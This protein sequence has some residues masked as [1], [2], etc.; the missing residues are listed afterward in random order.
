MKAFSFL[1]ILESLSKKLSILATKM[2]SDNLRVNH[3]TI[4]R[5]LR[6]SRPFSRTSLSASRRASF[7]FSRRASFALSRR[8]SHFAATLTIL[9]TIGVGNVFA[10]ETVTWIPTENDL[11]TLKKDKSNSIHYITVGT[12]EK[13]FRIYAVRNEASSSTDVKLIF[14]NDKYKMDDN[15]MEK[16]GLAVFVPA[17]S[18]DVLDIRF[19]MYT[20]KT[21]KTYYASGET[22][23]N[24]GT[25]TASALATSATAY[26]FFNTYS[27]STYYCAGGRNGGGGD[28]YFTK[29]EVVFSSSGGGETPDPDPDQPGT[30]GDGNCPESGEIY[31][32]EV[33]SATYSVPKDTETNMESA[34][35]TVVN[36]DAYIGNKHSNDAGK[37]QITTKGNGTVY[38]NGQDGYIKLVLDC[39][40]QTGDVLT[41]TN[42]DGSNPIC[43]T[44]DKTRATTHVTTNNTFN[45]PAVFDE[46]ST[47]Y[48]WRA[49]S[50][51]TYLHD[52][53]ITR[54]AS[55]DPTC[56]AV[57]A[58]TDL[59]CSARTNSSLTFGWTAA[60]NAS[61]YVV[62]LYSDA[63][64]TTQVSS[65]TI[66]GT[67]CTFTGL[68]GNTTYYCKVQSKGDGTTYCTNGGTTNATSGTTLTTPTITFN[69]GSYTISGPELN[70]STL[71][72]SNSN[73]TVTYTVTN[74]NGTGASINGTSFTATST[75]TA[76]VKATQAANG[77]Y[78]SGEATA[79]ITVNAAPVTPEP[80]AV[81]QVGTFT[82]M[83]MSGSVNLYWTMPTRPVT[84]RVDIAS[85]TL[86]T[87]EGQ[88]NSSTITKENTNEIKV[89]YSTNDTWQTAGVKIPLA[90]PQTNVESI[91]FEYKSASN[92]SVDFIPFLY[93]G[94]TRWV[95]SGF[96]KLTPTEW[97]SHTSVITKQ[98]WGENLYSTD[99]TIL[100]V[101]FY[102]N[103]ATATSGTFYIRNVVLNQG[104]QVAASGLI[105]VRKEGSNP[106]TPTDGT[107][108]YDGNGIAATCTD[109][110]LINGTTY[111]YA[112]YAH[113]GQGNYSEPLYWQYTY[114][115][116]VNTYAPDDTDFPNPE[117]GFYEQVQWNANKGYD[118]VIGDSYFD[119][120][121][122][123]NRSLILRIY[124]MD[125]NELRTNQQL[126]KDFIAMFNA[127]MEKF[128][129]NG[130]KCILR[131][132]YDEN[133]GD[134]AQDASPEIWAAHLADLAEHLEANADV[135]YVVQA[136][137]LGVWGE[138]YYSSEGTGNDEIK[139][140]IKNNLIDQ[141]LAAVPANRCVQLRT[142]KFKRDYLTSKS[143]STDALT[144]ATAYQNTPKA[145][146]GHHNDAFLNGEEN[147]GT[148]E[149]R[150]TDMAYIAQEC[151]YVPIGGETNLEESQVNDLYDK[152]CKG[153]VAEA[154]MAQLHYSY[155]NYSYST[156]VTNKWRDEGSY[157]RMSKQLGYRFELESATLPNKATAGTQMNVQL[158]IKNVGYA[159]LYNER[160]A[161]IVLKNNTNT[162]SIQLKSDPRTWAP[163]KVTTTI[164][165]NIELPNNMVEGTYDMYLHLP[166]ASDNIANNPKYAVRFANQGIWESETGYNKLNKQVVV[167]A[168]ELTTYTITFKNGETVLQTST[169]EYG[170]TPE[171][172]GETPTKA[173]DAQYTYTFSGWNPAITAVTGNATYNAT[174][175]QTAKTY[176][177][178]LNTN[179]GT[180]NAGNVT[181]YTYGEGATLPTNVTKTG[182]TFGGW[183]ESADFQGDAVTTILTTATGNKTY[184]AKWTEIKYTVTFN[185]NGGTCTTTSATQSSYNASITLPTPTRD[186][187]MFTGWYTA[188][189]GGSKIGDAGDSYTPTADITLYAQWEHVLVFNLPNDFNT[190]IHEWAVSSSNSANKLQYYAYILVEVPEATSEGSVCWKGEGTDANRT[191]L[192]MYTD[193]TLDNSKSFTYSTSYVSQT[194]GS[195]NIITI[196]EKYYLKFSTTTDWKAANVKIDLTTPCTTPTIN[197][198]PQGATYT[199]N[200]AAAALSVTATAND[201][202]LSYQWQSSTDNSEF[203]NISGATGNEY[204]PSTT[205]VGTTYYRC[206]VTNTTGGCSVTSASATI[207]VNAA[208]EP[209]PGTGDFCGKTYDFPTNSLDGWDIVKT[210][211][212][213]DVAI[214]TAKYQ[215][216][217]LTNG[218]MLGVGITGNS[219]SV[220]I[221]TK[222]SFT[223]ITK[224]SMKLSSINTENPTF[225]VNVVNGSTVTKIFTTTPKTANITKA[226]SNKDWGEHSEAVNKLSGKIQIVF[227]S[228]SNSERYAAIDDLVITT[229]CSSTPDPT[230]YTVTYNLGGGTGT[231]PTQAAT[232]A[233]GTFTLASADGITKDGHTFAGWND[234]TTTYAAGATYTMPASN[235][236]LTAQWTPEKYNIRYYE[237]VGEVNDINGLKEISIDD[238]PTSYTILD[239]VTLPALPA[240][241]GYKATGW[242]TTWC[243]FDDGGTGKGWAGCETTLGH[244]AGYYGHA[245]YI[246]KYTAEPGTLY[247]VTV[248]SA[249]N[250]TVAADKTTNVAQG[251]TVT[252]TVT[253]ASGYELGI[254]TV[255]DASDNNVTVT[256]NTFIMPASNV[257]VSATFTAIETPDPGSY[258]LTYDENKPAVWVDVFAFKNIPEAQTLTNGTGNVYN[259]NTPVITD[260]ADSDYPI[261]TFTGW[262]TA[263]DGTGTSYD[264][265]DEIT[266]TENTILYA[267]WTP[268]TFDVKYFDTNRTTPLEG[269][270]NTTYTFGVGIPTLPT[271]TKPGQTF[272]GWIAFWD[273][274]EREVT[275]IEQT[276]W[277]VLQLAAQWEVNCTM[278]TTTFANTKYTI[279]S[280]ALDLRTLISSK[281]SENSE[282]EITYA[283]T[284]GVAATIDGYSFT[285]DRI[286]VVT[287][288]ATQAANGGYCEKIMTA[289]I[290]V[291]M[292][293]QGGCAQMFTFD[294]NNNIS[295]P[296]GQKGSSY[297]DLS[298][299]ATINGLSTTGKVGIKDM[300]NN[301]KTSTTLIDE[302]EI[303]FPN[304][305]TYLK[306]E[307]LSTPLAAGDVITIGTGQSATT[308]YII[309]I[310]GTQCTSNCITTAGQLY[311]IP[312]G[313]S[314]IGVTTFYIWSANAE[315]YLKTI[316]ICRP[317]YKITYKANNG[318]QEDDVVLNDAVLVAGCP[319]TFTVPAGKQFAGWKDGTGTSYSVGTIIPVNNL[320]LF[321]QWECIEPVFTV[322]C[323]KTAY[324]KDDDAK[325]ITV[326][327]TA[328][329]SGGVTYQWYASDK[330]DRTTGAAITGAT[331]ASYTP[332]NL[333]TAGTTYYWCEISNSCTT[334]KTPTIAI[335]VSENKSNPTVTWTYFDATPTQS[336]TIH[337]GGGSYM[338]TAKVEEDWNGTLTADML[339][340]PDGIYV[341]GAM[342][343][344]N[345]ISAYFDVTTS[346]NRVANPTEIPFYLTLP[347]T[348]EYKPLVSIGNVPYEACATG[349]GTEYV[350]PV[351]NG[352]AKKDG[353]YYYWG[354]ENGWVS[355]SPNNS[356][357]GK[358][359]ATTFA[360]G[361]KFNYVHGSNS[362]TTFVRTFKAG[363]DKVRIY[364]NFRA[365]GMTVTDVYKHSDY[366]SINNQ[367][368]LNISS[369][370]TII[371]N[372]DVNATNLGESEYGFVDVI[373]NSPL[374]QNE[375]IA[376]KFNTD[377]V[378]V[379]GAAIIEQSAGT[380]E[381]ALSF[382]T[383]G[384]IEKKQSD[385]NFTY[386][387]TPS[388]NTLGTITYSS[389]NTNVATVNPNTG[390]VEIVATGV[391]G[392]TTTITATLA[393]SGCY[394]G[395][396]ATYTISVA[397]M[398]CDISAGTLALTNGAE[399]KCSGESVTLA[400]TGY[401]ADG[402]TIQWYKGDAIIEGATTAT[403]TTAAP[404]TYSVLV[405]EN[406]NNA[407]AKRSNTITITNISAE[408]SVTNI[409]NTWYIKSGRLTPPIALWKLEEG[410]TFLSVTASDGWGTGTGF[411]DGDDAK[412]FFEKDGI[413]YLTGTPPQANETDED[414]TYT[415]TLK[416]KDVCGGEHTIPSTITIVHQKNTDKH[417]LAFVV[418][419]TEKGGF[420]E[421]I[422]TAQT[423]NVP[424][425][426]EI[427]QEFDVLATNIYATDNEQLL[428][429][430]YSRFDI[431][432]I[433]DYPN[434]KKIGVNGK[435]Y[436]DAMGALIDIRPIFSMEAWVSNL[437][438]WN[439][440][441][442]KGEPVS[443]TTRQYS[444][445]L[446]CKD[447]EIFAGTTLITEGSGDEEMYRVTM[448]DAT[449]EDY[450]NLDKVE[451][452]PHQ[453]KE[454][455]KYGSNPALQGFRYVSSLSSMLPIGT[456]E[457]GAGKI[458]QVGLERQ[459]EEEARMMV[460]GVNA[461]AMERLTDD[462]ETVIINTLKYLMKKSAE[463]ISDCSIF[464]DNKAG[465]NQWNNPANW[466]PSYNSVPLSYQGA[467][468]L[469]PCIVSDVVAKAAKVKIAT[470]GTYDKGTK[471][472]NGSLTI[473]PNGALVVG[474]VISEVTAPNYYE[475]RPTTEEKLI[476]QAEDESDSQ[477]RL[478]ALIHD[479]K[480]GET[481]ATIQMW[482]PSHWEIDQETG[483]KKKYWSYVAVPIQEAP[484]PEFFYHGF[485]YLYDE[486]QGWIKK[487]DGTV[488]YPFQG[489]GAS[490]QTGNKETFYGKL[491]TTADQDIILTKTAG[492]GEGQNLIGN[493]WTA[494]IQI[495][496]FEEED[497]N[498]ATATVYVYNT[499][500]DDVYKNPTYVVGSAENDGAAT[501]GQWIGIP[502]GVAGLAE[503]T[504]LK[505]IPAMNAFQV[506]TAQETELHLN[507]NRLVRGEGKGGVN[508]ESNLNQ[509]MR[510]PHK[511]IEALMR[512]R[513][514]GE[515]THTDMWLLQDERFDY[516]FDNGWEAEF[517]E[518]DD[519]SA[520]LYAV[521]EIG[522]MAFLA[523]PE[524][525]GTL[526]GFAP[527]RDGA[528]YTFSFYY[529]GSQKLY[530]N[531]LKLQTSTLVSDNDTYLFTYEKGDEQRF[532]IS[533]APFNI[534]DISTGVGNTTNGENAKAVKFIKDDKIF[535]FVNGTLYDATGKMVIR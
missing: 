455:Y 209:D 336:G 311:T 155:L 106:T 82:G 482:N 59:T 132:A 427:S 70:L 483:K 369:D 341:Y 328:G 511:P 354:N 20:T 434:T 273:G 376:L 218:G 275:Q 471:Q 51:G 405:T 358:A 442:V 449:K 14:D 24:S 208:Q 118:A 72:T 15:S 75:G 377:R 178:T 444:M 196:G 425:Y 57:A 335:T 69:N 462:G 223:D 424:L 34:Y 40:I 60:S 134:G 447:H 182:Y 243:V 185:P 499:G 5:L 487:G 495:A 172:T 64:C 151:L 473:A 49:G 466:G 90:T 476:V 419:G 88:T 4:S 240:K 314:L 359:Q 214:K 206:V 6:V 360:D 317:A 104:T 309:T 138:W 210:N 133:S 348:N 295:N 219:G 330:N 250:G 225:T 409:V 103:P 534:P 530:L 491:A 528:E 17:T 507:Y 53:T 387:A 101:N 300:D 169:I 259:G 500:R 490:L 9:F 123:A 153:T 28:S 143:I 119:D 41:F 272:I 402:T 294:A 77:D 398:D 529:T 381:T 488:L 397:G 121:R 393:P 175:N 52:L 458:I 234:G 66:T 406:N 54:P 98:V 305:N 165:E 383:T 235:V 436:T 144:L 365:S 63:N 320:I 533:T 148:Y 312:T 461:Y 280:G 124:Y 58:P 382:A 48:V 486:T 173:E 445:L 494:P 200:T 260:D 364:A 261:Y 26:S 224:I 251:E 338:I 296:D 99:K 531:D 195:T 198:Q 390:E 183:Y 324:A 190:Q 315:R 339:T 426:N 239:E 410:T 465:D 372:G 472:A 25:V 407:C 509:P 83:G 108:V 217:P 192:Y 277:G 139:L 162:Y 493:S 527:S 107:Q 504:G 177:V 304:T 429:E 156:V 389:S 443:P 95:E 363:I 351:L 479:N 257:T 361:E 435:S 130:M 125:S 535:I 276:A 50:S 115:E 71:F 501:A 135:I 513:V 45:F 244:N 181:S 492:V 114:T 484:I 131:F 11:N 502:I 79:T 344:G 87:A 111:H 362:Q 238:A 438:N 316:D 297:L 13:S 432:C 459:Q 323:D 245:N 284:G 127:D 503:Y 480:N 394:K 457:D 137:F 498:D 269:M 207:T 197:G 318:T 395:A 278:P 366:F 38:F 345:T 249:T 222:E 39:P 267:Q 342:A 352:A 228:S 32:L 288:T 437:P 18:A 521:S 481:S 399:N 201:G 29:I 220:T 367:Y 439:D 189:S 281:N 299:Y 385:P 346:F 347:E 19:Y 270:V 164:D 302:N 231:L 518:G 431:I 428:K 67:S 375:I 89:E 68:S 256:D 450:V 174:F 246:V 421:G 373:L 233:G 448:V 310:S 440:K 96:A 152:Y 73:G 37:A 258:T 322:S 340:A 368:K 23:P 290:N 283:V 524:L 379:Q 236:T 307:N 441:G 193:G 188:T 136:G 420:T 401:T 31:S 160:Y 74:A 265:G 154:E 263:A 237:A 3:G 65:Q 159:P 343:Q 516:G 241:D 403:Y 496:N 61:E 292:P 86:S 408:A 353:N 85:A 452:N 142:P 44:T 514:A 232:T 84:T 166:D 203:T 229:E 42:G 467:R 392:Q 293:V 92:Q 120:A 168:T 30:G 326:T 110:G 374:A 505:V 252:L 532:I 43:F 337:Y 506:N 463:D 27:K 117:R 329:N 279:G 129:T 386:K 332:I 105:I 56:T 184:W 150:A 202:T 430:Y 7:G 333:S 478:G 289:T 497:F 370:Y 321:A 248:N 287:V 213:Y 186:G 378:R 212:A 380:I 180:I 526:L 400:L 264:A 171:Y 412:A 404:G 418:T 35:A 301:N 433:T 474:G 254:L 271:P 170:A 253:P 313:S 308:E 515:K 327:V 76:T 371:Y 22:C 388:T 221:T 204:T 191:T 140:S 460:V 176:S 510:A 262:N 298:S 157:A 350:I 55:S 268:R 266:I 199:Q 255:K 423:T 21:R 413:V 422:T 356:C 163:N 147:Q 47:I 468:I 194:F 469:E 126:P 158:N 415:L 226:E 161:Y 94:T 523:Q 247:T 10:Q 122:A 230:T 477:H 91:T 216:I 102:A 179:E 93:D 306:V 517:V 470:S 285:C 274:G 187:Y 414:K 286:G 355:P 384:T 12:G 16:A 520:Q 100:S 167:T 303:Y 489:I 109:N 464:F 357:S 227:N 512:I 508:S 331:A 417:V 8:A 205:E 453:E 451:E 291:A 116:G 113:D 1:T 2:H 211:D 519:R 334:V 112:A 319:N 141:L 80:E 282:G 391:E 97:T 145:R 215:D 525:D 396:T 46:A 149:N 128:R 454:G 485:T 522:K 146:L 325:P 416:V 411:D 349:G 36:G 81:P 62:T 446:Q 475:I 78:C 33:K 242:Y 456:I